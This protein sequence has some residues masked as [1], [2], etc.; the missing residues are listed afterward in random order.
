MPVYPGALISPL[1]SKPLNER[2]RLLTTVVRAPELSPK[3]FTMIHICQC[4]LLC[5][6][7]N[8]M[9]CRAGSQVSPQTTLWE[10]S[11]LLKPTDEV[12]KGSVAKNMIERLRVSNTEVVLEETKLADVQARLG[13]TTGQRGD[14]GTSLQW[15]CYELQTGESRSVLWL[16]AGE[17]D[18]GTVGGFQWKKITASTVVDKRCQPIAGATVKL[19]I[20]L[21]VG[22]ERSVLFKRLGRPTREHANRMDYVHDEEQQIRNQP[23]IESN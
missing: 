17:M 23:Y 11:L 20:D 19:P 9:S 5:I 12:P 15:L 1:R 8:A 21:H 3:I 14:A 13:G 2:N 10:P 7:V 22:M 4:V 6:V 18:A 16:M